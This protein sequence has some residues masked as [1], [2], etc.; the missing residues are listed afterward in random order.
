M[1]I[2]WR[3]PSAC[4]VACAALAVGVRAQPPSPAQQPPTFKS[5]AQVVEVDVRVF[6]KDGHFVTDLKPGDFV[7]KENGVP[8]QIVDLALI[9]AEPRTA[10]PNSEPRTPN[11]T[12]EP[13][14][15]RTAEPS[16]STFV[17]VFDT[18]HLSLNGLHYTQKAVAE[19]IDSRFRQGDLGGVVFDGK[20]ANNRLTTDREELLAAVDGMRQSAQSG[21]FEQFVH[22]EWP[23]IQDEHEAW[24]IAARND[25]EALGQATQ[26]ACNDRPDE[27]QGYA[28]PSQPVKAKARQVLD[29]ANVRTAVSL[30]VIEA[31]CDGLAKMAG[32]KTIVYVSEGFFVAGNEAGLQNVTGLANRAGAH[33]YTLDAR[34]LNHGSASSA[35]LSAAQPMNPSGGPT[36]FDWNE[37]STNALAV[38]TG[39]IPIR[40]EN[41]FGRALDQIQTDAGTYYVIGYTPSQQTFDG[42]YRRIDVTA[43]RPGVKIRARRGYLALEPAKLLKPVSI[44]PPGPAPAVPLSVAPADAT[45]EAAAAPT[46]AAASAPMGTVPAPSRENTAAEATAV[47]TRIEKGGLVA[48]LRGADRGAVD[49]AASLGWA[50]YQTGDV[51]SAERELTK[52]AADPA[53]HPWVQY[54]LGLCH[55]ALNEYAAAAQSWERVRSSVPTFEPL[56]FN[57]ADAYSLQNDRKRALT[58]LAAAAERWPK[59]AEIFDAEGVIQIHMR[60]LPDAIAS[61]EHATKLAP[62]DPL[63]FFNLA[64]AHHAAA[65]RL[66]QLSTSRTAQ[67]QETPED[68]RLVQLSN[69]GG[70]LGNALWH[71][72]AAIK[73][74]RRVIALK[75]D[76]V[77]QAKKGLAALQGK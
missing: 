12:S 9:G 66:R 41:N 6:D 47:R 15:P 65:L 55:L 37:D 1:K 67:L 2:G 72:S 3:I 17:F 68:R 44:T 53:A 33:F 49:D 39:G 14:P 58:V 77:E 40:N 59:D 8:Q 61:F 62:K 73:A 45:P 43:T 75:G 76:Y 20:M 7:V 19:F 26:R 5:G 10:N 42:K 30:R 25:G 34:G 11:A 74:Y 52:A 56:Y 27:C 60:E 23:R 57:L 69:G 31:L 24:A 21:N 16:P 50:A 13:P 36:Q 54:V 29:Q 32:P 46:T 22:L 71:R 48:A 35:I 4:V 63:G 51:E 38:D 28:D 64:S 18:P 70:F